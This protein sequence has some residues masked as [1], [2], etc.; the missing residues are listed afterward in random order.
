MACAVASS[1]LPDTGATT[2]VCF[3]MAAA[4]LAK[5]CT[6]VALGDVSVLRAMR[7]VPGA[8]AQVLATG[9]GAPLLL[10]GESAG[11]RIVVLAFALADSDLPLQVAFP[12]LLANI[13]DALA[14]DAAGGSGAISGMPLR[15]PLRSD[16]VALEVAVPDGT[17]RSLR[18]DAG[19]ALVGD[20]RTPGIYRF[21]ARRSD[22]AREAWSIA[23][24]PV[25]AGESPI[26][27]QATLPIEQASGLGSAITREAVGRA[28]WWAP[29]AALVLALVLLEW[30]VAYR[31][32]LAWWW[33]ALRD[34]V[35]AWRPR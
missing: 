33:A 32:A 1:A 2:E 35:R 10:A 14:P 28:E 24:N 6:H 8:W 13:V 23:I 22:G 29:L 25:D 27:P 21:A 31:G 4:M 16:V 20:T 26:A 18:I 9:D 3:A 30:L 19:A 15:V 7:I 34:G 17:I 11:R 12:V 5:A